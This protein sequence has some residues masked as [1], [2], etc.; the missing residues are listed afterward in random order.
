[1]RLSGRSGADEIG[2][3]DTRRTLVRHWHVG[4]G[5]TLINGA[6]LVCTLPNI[7]GLNQSLSVFPSFAQHR[8]AA[9]AL[10]R[11]QA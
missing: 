1:M 7:S 2:A 4:H 8:K 3:F 5:Q 11:H 10:V 9:M 6:R